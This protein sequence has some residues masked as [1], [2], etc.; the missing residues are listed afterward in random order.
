MPLYLVGLKSFAKKIHN[1]AGKGNIMRNLRFKKLILALTIAVSVGVFLFAITGYAQEGERP[2]Y[3]YLGKGL[4]QESE[5]AQEEV[6]E[7]SD[8]YIPEQVIAGAIGGDVLPLEEQ[9]I[10]P[11]Q[12]I[13][14]PHSAPELASTVTRNSG[15]IQKEG[16]E[17]YINVEETEENIQIDVHISNFNT[18]EVMGEDGRRYYKTSIPDSYFHT[19]EEGLPQMPYI[20][21]LVSIP[22]QACDIELKAFYKTKEISHSD[23]LLYP[24]PKKIVKENPQG[25]QY[26]ED[27][28]YID[29]DAYQEDIFMPEEIARLNQDSYFRSVRMLEI[30]VYPIQYNPKQNIL[31]FYPSLELNISYKIDHTIEL[32]RDSTEHF[33]GLIKNLVINPEEESP[34]GKS[35]N[36]ASAQTMGSVTYLND[37]TLLDINNNIDYLIITHLD[38]YDS[39]QLADFA[40]YRANEEA[41]YTGAD[42]NI[43]IARVSDIYN[44][45]D[46][47]NI[48]ESEYKIKAFVQYAYDNWRKPPS[49]LLLMGDVMWVPTYYHYQGYANDDWFGYVSGKD[50]WADMAVGRL[51]VQNTAQIGYI[52]DKIY[53]YEYEKEPILA[54]D[55]RGRA[56]YVEGTYVHEQRMIDLLRNNGFHLTELYARRGDVSQDFINA[57]NFGQNIVYWIGHGSPGGW[58]Y[59]FN[60]GQGHVTDLQNK[61]YPII[62]TT[63]CSTARLAPESVGEELVRARK[64]A[65]AYY[66]ATDVSG[67][68]ASYE[69]LITV[70]DGFEY[71]LGQAILLG[72]LMDNNPLMSQMYILL[73]DPALHVFGHRLNSSQPDLTVSSE[74]ISYDSRTEE[75]T[76]KVTNLGSADAANVEVEA[77]LCGAND[78]VHPFAQFT[79]PS[80]PAGSSI[81]V[82][83]IA[84]PLLRRGTYLVRTRIDPQNKIIESFELNNYAAKKINTI[85]YSIVTVLDE[86]G[87]P[88]E[89]SLVKGYSIE[90]IYIAYGYTDSSGKAKLY[91]QEGRQVYYAARFNSL[92]ESY[93]YSDIVTTPEDITISKPEQLS[94]LII[95]NQDRRMNDLGWVMELYAYD[96]NDRLLGVYRCRTDNFEEVERVAFPM[97][98]GVQFYFTVDVTFMP[99]KHTTHHITQ[100][101]SK[102]LTAPADVTIIPV[103]TVPGDYPTI[104]SAIDAAL[105]NHVILIDRGVYNLD[106]NVNITKNIVLMADDPDPDNTV[107]ILGDYHIFIKDTKHGFPRRVPLPDL[108][109]VTIEGVTITGYRGTSENGPIQNYATRL[110]LRDCKI[111]DN[112]GSKVSAVYSRSDS[113]L[114]LENVLIAQNRNYPQVRQT[115]YGTDEGDTH[116]GT[117]YLDECAGLYAYKSTIAGNSNETDSAVI[118]TGYGWQRIPITY[119]AIHR[120]VANDL[121]IILSILWD[122][123]EGKDISHRNAALQEIN[124]TDTDIEQRSVIGEG[125]FNIIHIDPA[126]DTNYIPQNPILLLGN[127]GARFE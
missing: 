20:R 10:P 59:F 88:V 119:G 50:L 53:Q 17:V 126:F 95:R 49:Y 73:G 84:P 76:V 94:E 54:G 57:I 116:C 12:R 74:G 40:Q 3:F 41:I 32:K 99:N 16:G 125:T 110:T 78:M 112:E 61:N 86:C 8:N 90:D 28:F 43:G 80:V 29:E 22:D 123:E 70:F 7:I 56:L 91:I 118:Q 98:Q 33:K 24:S 96:I 69:T 107:L 117:I 51:S 100:I 68:S 44:H 2:W 102:I 46:F 63:S 106:S 30:Y 79:I 34:E 35:I 13:E 82:K 55:Y 72:E 103:I 93:V 18:E 83:V 62:L 97:N 26:I 25:F 64:G 4:S 114:H 15:E 66:G 92:V 36:V 111:M 48:P 108:E 39:A 21:K 14:K 65:V 47:S 75:L 124:I 37:S 81:E 58:E 105:S 52:K 87:Q 45:P 104:Q 115:G 42:F 67:H 71:N 19:E 121:E 27:E 109:G 89:G 101:S 122:N 127:M 120:D 6:V 23:F 11:D 9:T 5:S 85:Y 60:I 1:T 113:L 77:L 38:F 31:K